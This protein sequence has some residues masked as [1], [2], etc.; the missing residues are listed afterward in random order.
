MATLTAQGVLN[1][2]GLFAALVPL[3]RVDVSGAPGQKF[4]L[5][6]VNLG[7]SQTAAILALG[8]WC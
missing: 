8:L 1:A 4:L 2:D 3:E 7:W 6:K 5:E